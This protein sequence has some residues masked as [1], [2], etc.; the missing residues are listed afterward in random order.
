MYELTDYA[1]DSAFDRFFNHR[2]VFGTCFDD[3]LVNVF[4]RRTLK[5]TL[6]ERSL[7]RRRIPDEKDNFRSGRM[8]L[9]RKYGRGTGKNGR[10]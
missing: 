1:A 6:E 5:M 9:R 8:L 2:Q 10:P 7:A 3:Q 4:I